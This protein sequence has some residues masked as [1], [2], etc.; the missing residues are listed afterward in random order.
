MSQRMPLAKPFRVLRDIAAMCDDEGKQ[1]TIIFVKGVDKAFCVTQAPDEILA[2][3][4][5]DSASL[6]M[7]HILE[8][9]AMIVDPDK[10]LSLVEPYGKGL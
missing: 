4:K 10:D 7:R 8:R 3:R 1:G 6:P 5:D 2:L 9:Q